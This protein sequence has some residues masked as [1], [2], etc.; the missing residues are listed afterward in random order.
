MTA[1]DV[2]KDGF[3][4]RLGAGDT[5]IWYSDWL[6]SGLLCDKLDYL[7]ISDTHLYLRDIWENGNWC[8]SKLAT[9]LSEEIKALCNTLRSPAHVNPNLTDTRV[10]KGD[11]DGVYKA[12]SGYN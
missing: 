9:P 10:W 11:K 3:Q 1:R 12:C 5:S 4:M 2:F 8:F 7:H 6:G